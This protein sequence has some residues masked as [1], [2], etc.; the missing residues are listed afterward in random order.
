MNSSID[1]EEIRIQQIE[2]KVK[3]RKLQEQLRN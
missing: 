1:L 3:E 2:K